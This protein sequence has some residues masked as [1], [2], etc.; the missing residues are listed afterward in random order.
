MVYV[1]R[2]QL[3]QEAQCDTQPMSKRSWPPPPLYCCLIRTTR[4]QGACRI[5]CRALWLPGAH[6]EQQRRRRAA[7]STVST[8]RNVLECRMGSSKRCI[9]CKICARMETLDLSRALL[10]SSLAVFGRHGG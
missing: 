8:A 5:R 7:V 2:A 10:F 1:Q 3:D 4:S 9:I 6:L